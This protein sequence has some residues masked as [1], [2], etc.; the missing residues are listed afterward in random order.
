MVIFKKKKKIIDRTFQKNRFFNAPK[1][2]KLRL[3]DSALI[4]LKETRLELLHIG[5][6]KRYLRK[7]MAKKNKNIHY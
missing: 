2:I 6:I 1:E 4:N 3:G 5:R 7:L